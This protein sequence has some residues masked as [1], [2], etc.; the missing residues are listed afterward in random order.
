MLKHSTYSLK[1]RFQALLSP[2]LNWLISHHVSAN[3]LTLFSCGL[4]ITYAG[5]LAW[6]SSTYFALI[7]LPFFLLIRMA[8]NALDGMVA[9]T[10]HT[11]TPL[12]SVLNEVCDIISDAI[13]FSA[14]ILFLPVNT[15]LWAILIILIILSEFIALAI[16]QAIGTRPFFGPFGKS[17]RA[18]Y[19]AMI[20]IVY[21]LFPNPSQLY[22]MLAFIGILLSLT[23]LLNRFKL[24]RS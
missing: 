17:D 11:K 13:L 4:C 22:N 5:L 20:A 18:V 24:L 6:S 1:S 16:F 3:F 2:I 14:F 9:T 7:A 19:L 21:L 23:T 15:T 12:G 8:L 10:T